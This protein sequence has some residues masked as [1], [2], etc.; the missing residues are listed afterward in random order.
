MKLVN[1]HV[2]RLLLAFTIILFSTYSLAFKVKNGCVGTQETGGILIRL[3]T[4][5]YQWPTKMLAEAYAY[6]KRAIWDSATSEEINF[7]LAITGI[8]KLEIEF[9][10]HLADPE[11]QD[12]LLF[13]Q[14]FRW[15]QLKKM[16]LIPDYTED[17][18]NNTFVNLSRMYRWTQIIEK[19]FNPETDSEVSITW[20]DIDLNQR[21]Q[22]RLKYTT[23]EL[24][25]VSEELRALKASTHPQLPQS[26]Q[27]ELASAQDR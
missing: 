23:G 26:I 18:V 3:K 7:P 22:A 11:E 19:P 5:T 21:E 8:I 24:K 27:L 12:D 1:R 4:V 17:N 10:N 15:E 2:V 20:Q 25:R 14:H 9:A 6:P 16:E 13:L